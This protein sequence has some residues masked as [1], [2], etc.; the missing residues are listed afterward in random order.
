M[1]I[2]DQFPSN[3][4]KCADLKGRRVP[5][6]IREVTVEKVGQDTKPI[7]YFQS[8]EKGLCLNKTNSMMIAE[9]AGTPE[10]DSW[11]G[12]TIVMYPAKV[13]F[14]GQRVDAIRVDWPADAKRKQE[15][16]SDDIPF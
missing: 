5:A 9:I 8:K 15:V 16:G 12:V 3:Y 2:N 14:Q 11:E 6:T 10:T 7:V 4:L 1:N 13:D